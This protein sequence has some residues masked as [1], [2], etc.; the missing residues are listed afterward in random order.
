MTALPSP[1]ETIPEPQ[2]RPLLQREAIVAA[3]RELVS[4]KG[5]EALSLRRLAANLGVTA[6]AL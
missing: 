2:D 1:S 4:T 3:A 6:P 5:L